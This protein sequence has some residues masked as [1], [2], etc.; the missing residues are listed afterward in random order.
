MHCEKGLHNWC[1]TQCKKEVELKLEQDQ[2]NFEAGK[3]SYFKCTFL[4]QRCLSLVEFVPLNAKDQITNSIW[5]TKNISQAN[6]FCLRNVVFDIL[7]EKDKKCF[8][9]KVKDITVAKVL[10]HFVYDGVYAS[11]EERVRVGGCL[12]ITKIVSNLLGISKEITDN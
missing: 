9:E 3:K 2:A 4:F 8:Q 1:F 12:H 6:F 7:L 10:L 5:A 11:K